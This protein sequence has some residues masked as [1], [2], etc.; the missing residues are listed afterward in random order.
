[1]ASTSL[2]WLKNLLPKPAPVAAPLTSP[3]IST[4]STTAGTIG[5]KFVIRSSFFVSSANLFNL[6][7]GTT[8]IPTFGSTVATFKLIFLLTPY[9]FC[10]NMLLIT[11]EKRP[12]DC[13]SYCYASHFITF[14]Q[15]Y[16]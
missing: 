2:I 15:L 8:T 4:N 3:A 5:G 1:M 6:S 14:F 11:R 7:S 12:Y 9:Q 10:D 16:P 13:V